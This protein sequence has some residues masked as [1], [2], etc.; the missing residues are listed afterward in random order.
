MQYLYFC[1]LCAHYDNNVWSSQHAL[2]QR[3]F[4]LLADLPSLVTLS[5]S[6]MCVILSF[7]LFYPLFVQ[8]PTLSSVLCSPIHVLCVVW[9]SDGSVLARRKEE[10]AS[11]F[12]RKN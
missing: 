7:V 2:L 11:E 3:P 1:L 9:L 8:V 10:Q 6:F 12:Y 4:L 5:H